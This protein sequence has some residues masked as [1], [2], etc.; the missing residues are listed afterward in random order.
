MSGESVLAKARADAFLELQKKER[1]VVSPLFRISFFTMKH[2]KP[3]FGLLFFIPVVV[4]AGMFSFLSSG[5]SSEESQFGTVILSAHNMPI[6]EAVPNI[7][8]N[9]TS[10]APEAAIISGDALE[11]TGGIAGTA[12]EIK[13][14]PASDTV[15]V[16]EVREGDTLSGIAEMF[17]VSQSTILWANDL[18]NSKSIKKGDKL[19]I[20][21]ISG[22]K[23]IV[24]K[25]DT[26]ESI[27]KKYGGDANEI[28][29]FNDIGEGGLTVGKEIIIPDGEMNETAPTPKKTTGGV[30]GGVIGSDATGV[31]VRPTTGTRTQ[32]NHGKR[33]SAV[34]I[35][36]KV[37]TTVYAAAKGT[38]LVAKM[39]GWNGGYGNYVVI[40]HANGLQTLYG[41]L[42]AIQIK[43]GETVSQGQVIGAMGS[44][45]NSTG[46]HL[47]F[48]I[49]GGKYGWNPF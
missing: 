9:P 15:S 16:Y 21:P 38:V 33:K 6:L 45:G 32:G 29:Q 48:E 7:D 1:E 14:K 49:L 30:K 4:S 12:L 20:L 5:S 22:V 25:G 44:S 18:K 28:R 17:G 40:Q 27:A 8:P 41:H 46:S 26:V 35:A 2:Y 23:Y 13:E 24:K 42:S 39:G 37:G 31:F 11:P 19:I 36:N 47:H 43:A 10:K 34:D 3:V